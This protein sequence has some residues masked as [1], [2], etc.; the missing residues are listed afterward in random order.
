MSEIRTKEQRKAGV[1]AVLDQHGNAWLA[2][3]S[4]AGEPRLIAIA[5]VWHDGRI[6][7]ATKGASPTARNLADNGRARLALGSP[8]DVVMIDATAEGPLP[9]ANAGAIGSAFQLAAGWDPAEEGLDW[10]YFV[11]TP[12]RIEAYRGYSELEG[13]LVM[14]DGR[15]LV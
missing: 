12:A 11:L 14:K 8:D 2:T 5:A 6:V 3:S 7:M 9:V 15:W 4:R 1:L 10:V 13:R